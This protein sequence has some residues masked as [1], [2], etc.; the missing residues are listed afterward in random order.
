MKNLWG[1]LLGVGVLITMNCGAQSSGQ[2]NFALTGNYPMGS[3]SISFTTAD[4]NGD[5]KM[6][7]LVRDTGIW[8]YT[9]NGNGQ[10]GSNSWLN[11]T[12]IRSFRMADINGD[13]LLDL[14]A[15]DGG[16]PGHILVFT[17]NG[18]GGFG[19]SASYSVGFVPSTPLIADIN[20]DGKPDII[21]AN[22]ASGTLSILTNAG[23]GTFLLASTPATGSDGNPAGVMAVDINN[24]GKLALVCANAGTPIY[25]TTLSVL[26]NGG[27]GFFKLASTPSVGR[28]P[29]SLVA[30]DVN[31]D[32]KIDLVC[33]NYMDKTLS[34][35]TNNGIGGFVANAT[36]SIGIAPS[37]LTGA[38]F[39][40][41]GRL[42]L[43][44]ADIIG[45]TIL[46]LTNNGNGLWGSNTVFS[47]SRP[48]GI[49]T[50]DINGDGQTDLICGN[51][52][53][54]PVSSYTSRSS[55][56]VFTSVPDLTS[57][58]TGTNLLL[59]W[60]SAR[61]NWTLLQCTDLTTGWSG[62]S[63]T[64]SDDGTNK[65]VTNTTSSGNLYFRLSHP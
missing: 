14:I 21:C 25:G 52:G 23:N 64:I 31:G 22:Q 47:T 28:N 19:S 53:L 58:V 56:S 3:N 46:I 65:T 42:D 29:N 7:L 12:G 6:D 41:D 8:I 48:N 10:F 55:V 49:V 13:G 9:N 59:S 16:F 34:V 32:G 37:L 18:A 57:K 5:G 63:G 1:I 62:Y 51:D 60:P 30:T 39:N 27:N 26:T 38:D 45:N 36:L 44:C 24:S 15:S 61:T 43:V 11:I 50:L 2:L 4:M 20:N 54:H 17:N 35:L 40:N 33:A